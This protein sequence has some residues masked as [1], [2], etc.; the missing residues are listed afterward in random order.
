[1]V[2]TIQIRVGDGKHRV[3]L[4]ATLTD[5]GVAVQIFGGEKPHVGAVVMTLPRPSLAQKDVVSCNSFVLPRIN[6]K[7]D[8]LARL[9]AEKIAKQWN[10]A[11]VVVAGLHIDKATA[12]DINKL[13]ANTEKA[14]EQLI[15]KR[16]T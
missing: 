10:E 6:H 5:D 4:M 15:R 14:V 12:E 11:V 3:S 16:N 13:V 8:D 2:E 7:E 1:M 9:M